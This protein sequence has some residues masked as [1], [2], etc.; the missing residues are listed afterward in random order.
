L[1]EPTERWL[2]GARE[3]KPTGGK[4]DLPLTLPVR[5]SRTLDAALTL[6]H[7]VVGVGL[8]PI[9]VPIFAKLAVWSILALS[10]ARILALRRI[11]ISLTL[12]ANGKLDVTRGDNQLIDCGV[13]PETS[14]FPWLVVLRLVCGGT[15]ETLVM[16]Q[17]ALGTEGHRQL[18]TWLRWRATVEAA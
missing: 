4:I 1:A 5:R 16:P 13:V 14:V 6:A 11:P 10:L 18:R 3:F 9:A 8:V 17:D 2:S 7:V 12:K 15:T